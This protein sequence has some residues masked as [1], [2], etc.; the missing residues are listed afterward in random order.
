MRHGR[1][2]QRRD[3]DRPQA[4]RPGGGP[5]WIVAPSGSLVEIARPRFA[6]RATACLPVV[7]LVTLVACLGEVGSEGGRIGVL[8]TFVGQPFG[9]MVLW[10]VVLGFG[11]VAL[12]RFTRFCR[13]FRRSRARSQAAGARAVAFTQSLLA[14]V[15]FAG[16]L[17]SVLDA[18][19][20]AAAA[21]RAAQHLSPAAVPGAVPVPAPGLSG[22]TLIC[23]ALSGGYLLARS[24]VRHCARPGI[25]AEF[26][27]GFGTGFDAGLDA[28]LDGGFDTGFDIGFDA[29]LVGPPFEN[30]RP[31]KPGVS[32]PRR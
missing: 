31:G 10:P 13:G 6:D 23:V 26:D 14:T 15:L 8:Q 29:G 30:G 7:K 12:S 2:G 5:P 20:I 18:G 22:M 11:A 28:G 19:S 27:S 17:R 1:T 3:A 16:T 4:D 9:W 24:R 32:I 25:D 21:A